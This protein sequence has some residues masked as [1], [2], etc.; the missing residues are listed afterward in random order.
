MKRHSETVM[1]SNYQNAYCSLRKK[2]LCH[3]IFGTLLRRGV[4]VDYQIE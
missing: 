4:S 3:I 1:V 2:I